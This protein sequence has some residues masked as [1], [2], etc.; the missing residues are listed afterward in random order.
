M[1]VNIMTEE[2]GWKLI[3]KAIS[4]SNE[5]ISLVPELKNNCTREDYLYFAQ[6]MGSIS[7][8]ISYQI[9]KPIYKKF[10]HLE[11]KVQQMLTTKGYL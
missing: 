2:F 8:D 5:I 11:V 4:S 7:A 3:C 9:L 1:K 10:P 6:A